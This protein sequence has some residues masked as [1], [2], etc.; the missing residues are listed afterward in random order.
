MLINFN[1]IYR[2]HLR[3]EEVLGERILKGVKRGQIDIE[4][5]LFS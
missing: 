2:V 5:S 4:Y 3:A 1:K